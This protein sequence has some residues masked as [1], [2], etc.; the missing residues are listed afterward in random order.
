MYQWVFS[1]NCSLFHSAVLAVPR[2]KN[3]AGVSLWPKS[4]QKLRS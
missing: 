1:V 4:L 2:S 3:Q